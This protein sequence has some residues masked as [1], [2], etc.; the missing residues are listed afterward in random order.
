MLHQEYVTHKLDIRTINSYA[1]QSKITERSIDAHQLR[2]FS[3]IGTSLKETNLLPEG[4][5]YFLE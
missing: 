3:K 5:Y 4:M 1:H 2:P